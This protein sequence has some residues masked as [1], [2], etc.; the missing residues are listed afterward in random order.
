HKLAPENISRRFL[1][2]YLG[3]VEHKLATMPMTNEQ[4]LE[5][6]EMD[7]FEITYLDQCF[8]QMRHVQHHLG[9]IDEIMRSHHLPLL[10]WKGYGGVMQ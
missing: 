6:R 10:L 7:G 8:V 5:K 3:K 4:L 2:A 9:E 1:L